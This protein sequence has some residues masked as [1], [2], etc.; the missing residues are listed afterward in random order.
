MKVAILAAGLGNR[1]RPAITDCPKAMIRIKDKPLIQY[2]VDSVL[3]ANFTYD[4]IYIIG[5][6]KIEIMQDYFRNTHIHFIYNPHYHSMNNIY[7]FL[8]SQQIGDDL[9]LINSDGLYHRRMISLLLSDDF[10]SC[11]LVDQQKRLT[12]ESMRVKLEGNR[13]LYVNKSLFLS[14]A[15]GEYIG[16]SKIGWNDLEILY[17]RAL[18]M[19]EA[20]KKDAWYEDVFEACAAEIEMRAIST[21]GQPWIEIDDIHDLKEANRLASIIVMD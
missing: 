13:L 7:S 10:P 5:G 14:H 12:E 4:D 2:Q 18:Q 17:Q 11:I 8:L 3:K 15:D 1:L 20:G 21:L 6:Y 16:I 19:V 9:L